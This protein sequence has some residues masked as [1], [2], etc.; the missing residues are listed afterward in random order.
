MADVYLFVSAATNNARVAL[1]AVA[2]S[3]DVFRIDAIDAANAVQSTKILTSSD[4]GTLQSMWNGDR[5]RIHS[6]ADLFTVA[7]TDNAFT[8]TNSLD[9]ANSN[10][11]S[12]EVS[13]TVG[14]TAAMM[15]II[16]GGFDNT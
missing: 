11:A 13:L 15:A 2:A 3:E 7:V 1:V 16:H 12:D 6:L 4:V 8:F 9:L 14:Q 10:V 5:D